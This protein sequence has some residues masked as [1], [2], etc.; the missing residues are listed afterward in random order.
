[1]I[2]E[3]YFRIKTILCGSCCPFIHVRLLESQLLKR[4][5]RRN[6]VRQ[7]DGQT[8]G[9]MDGEKE[10]WNGWKDDGGMKG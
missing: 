6:N 10:G 7:K 1:M 9:W 3:K 5:R 2:T 4:K 8:D